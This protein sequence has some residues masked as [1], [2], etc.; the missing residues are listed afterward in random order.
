[1]KIT[2]IVFLLLTV[3]AGVTTAARAELPAA[4]ARYVDANTLAVVRIDA[5]RLDADAAADFLKKGLAD[6]GPAER[7]EVVR[8]ARDGLKQFAEELAPTTAAGVTR[9][10]LLV[11]PATLVQQ[12]L[13]VIVIPTGGAEQATAV[14]NSPAVARI[15]RA[16]SLVAVLGLENTVLLGTPATTNAALAVR[17]VARPELAGAFG[18]DNTAV[19][20]AFVPSPLVRLFAAQAVRGQMQQNPAIP[21]ALPEVMQGL[22]RATMTL[23]LPPGPSSAVR[24]EF[25]D[26]AT[27][28]KAA[29]L[30]KEGLA[31]AEGQLAGEVGPE[32][33]EAIT[34]AASPATDG[35]A[36]TVD[37]TPQEAD[38]L[39]PFLG[40][41][42]LE[43]RKSAKRVASMSNLRQ[44]GMGINIYAS[45]NGGRLPRTLEDIG[46]AI[47][48]TDPELAKSWAK[49]STSPRLAAGTKY[50]LLRPAER[51]QDVKDSGGTV[52]LYEPVPAGWDDK[53]IVGF[54][55]GHA[56]TVTVERL[57]AMAK[58]QGFEIE[59]AGAVGEK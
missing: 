19:S 17:P 47:G 2:R 31:S 23:S 40:K 43:A 29:A 35:P 52:L 4:V 30:M 5:S 46:A 24:M 56:E 18:D 16:Y 57:E 21:A 39:A 59:R 25:A 33:A 55:D 11:T 9:A 26:A 53:V 54:A 27:A 14:V 15:G 7:D 22:A 58:E 36:V 20:A 48:M 10:Y 45:D 50:V 13:P 41:V 34:A 32:Q 49:M 42:L 8:S 51:M 28:G 6:A 1:M 12:Q 3:L 44:M 37:V 38:A